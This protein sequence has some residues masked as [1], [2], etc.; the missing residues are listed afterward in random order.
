MSKRRSKDDPSRV[1]Y[2]KEK[3]EAQALGAILRTL[4]NL[5]VVQK[6]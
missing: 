4:L 6:S 2:S 1:Q 3:P 5:A